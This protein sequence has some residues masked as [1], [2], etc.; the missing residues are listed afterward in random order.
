MMECSV[1]EPHIEFIG[2]Q[3]ECLT[4]AVARLRHMR[5]LTSI[6]LRQQRY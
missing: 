2:T 6:V 1:P 4:G 5:V 3:L